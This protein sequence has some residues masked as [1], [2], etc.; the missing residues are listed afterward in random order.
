MD[1]L[2]VGRAGARDF[3]VFFFAVPALR[4]GF[5]VA[6]RFVRFGAAGRRAVPLRAAEPFR[7]VALLRP[8]LRFFDDARALL[9]VRRVRPADDR[10]VFRE[11]PRPAFLAFLAT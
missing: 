2:G 9:P 1:R 10:E 11:P 5:V 3:D 7:A 8:V 6:V 4:R